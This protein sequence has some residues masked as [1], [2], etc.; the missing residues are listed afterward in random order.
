MAP[1]WGLPGRT[2]TR[3]EDLAHNGTPVS[4]FADLV[5]TGVAVWTGDGPSTAIA[6]RG[7]HVAALG[8]EAVACS[9]PDVRHLPGHAVLPGL[10]D[11]HAHPLEA[12][13]GRA[14]ADLASASN[15]HDLRQALTSWLEAHDRA[16]WLEGTGWDDTRNYNVVPVR[17]LDEIAPDRPAVAWSVDGHAAWANTRALLRAGL[18]RSVP[19][20]GVVERDAHGQP[21]GVVRETAVD[22]LAEVMPVPARRELDEAAD[23][24]IADLLGAGITTVVEAATDDV[25]LGTWRRATRR[26]AVL[27][28]I[29]G[30]WPVEL[31]S[32][33]A[34]AAR[35]VGVTAVK[36]YL[37]GVAESRTAAMIQPYD[38]GTQGT[39]L[40]SDADLDGILRAAHRAGL[41]VHVHAIG[42]AA[43]RQFLDAVERTGPAPG[44]PP[45]VAHAQFV[46]VGDIA[47]FAQLGV[48]VSFQPLWAYP[49]PFLAMTEPLVGAERWAQAYPIGALLRASAG[50]CYGSDWDVSPVNPWPSLETAVTRR[51]P[52][53]SGPPHAPEQAVDASSAVQM[54]TGQASRAVSPEAGRLYVGGPAD[55]VVVDRDPFA[56]PPEDWS[57]IRVVTTVVGGRLAPREDPSP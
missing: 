17:L 27:P 16:A 32:E 43:V 48:V 4:C 19:A 46:A 44:L 51:D 6:I 52:E 12:G 18:L 37:D 40:V 33:V 38:D 34:R 9:A 10:L 47:R 26:H 24:A 53:R 20:G 2:R 35:R 54:A 14:R 11:T 41:Q 45:I 22:E 1:S 50:V 7:Q 30:A 49:D 31:P 23:R 13:L 39:L 25:A 21:T 55:F 57:T 29:L 8:D 36:V 42:D 5:V 56:I 28:H 3:R 15:E